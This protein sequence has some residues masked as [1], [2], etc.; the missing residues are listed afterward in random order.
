MEARRYRVVSSV[1]AAAA[2]LSVLL[3]ERLDVDGVQIIFGLVAA[4]AVI[5]GVVAYF[6]F[7][8]GQPV[9]NGLPVN[10]VAEMDSI[11]DLARIAPEESRY[12][13]WAGSE[14]NHF[15]L[16]LDSRGLRSARVAGR[17]FSYEP[18]IVREI[19]RWK[20]ES[21]AESE[22][23]GAIYIDADGLGVDY[24][25][26]YKTNSSALKRR[27]SVTAGAGFDKRCG[28]GWGGMRKYAS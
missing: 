6:S 28:V 14:G 19:L 17:R 12:R 27:S 15:V 20:Y 11:A 3:S 13:S 8:W 9:S 18:E 21:I 25:K 4:A 22:A 10:E 24:R 2:V 23:G 26:D 7:H 5:V 1:C 16:V